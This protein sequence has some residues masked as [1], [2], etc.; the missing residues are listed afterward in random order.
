MKPL[1]RSAT[2][3]VKYSQSAV[4]MIH[5][6][7]YLPPHGADTGRPATRVPATASSGPIIHGRGVRNASHATA[8]ASATARPPAAGTASRIFTAMPA[9]DYSRCCDPS[10][11]GRVEA[12]ANRAGTAA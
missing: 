12:G 4:P 1:T 5:W 7:T 11:N 2:S 8:A 10:A 9:G 6:P 3:G